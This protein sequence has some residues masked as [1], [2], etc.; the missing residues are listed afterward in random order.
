MLLDE[1]GAV[2]CNQFVTLIRGVFKNFMQRRPGRGEDQG[3]DIQIT[4]IEA[5]ATKIKGPSC[6]KITIINDHPL[7][8]LIYR[9]ARHHVATPPQNISFDFGDHLLITS[10]STA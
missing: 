4:Y 10:F 8:C 2:N 9:R 1:E 5:F 3:I 6:K 7:D